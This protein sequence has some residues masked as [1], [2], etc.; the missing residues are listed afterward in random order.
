[1]RP[2]VDETHETDRPAHQLVKVDVTIQRQEPVESR[3]PQPGDALP[4][5]HHQHQQTIE[6]NALTCHRKPI[7]TFKSI[8]P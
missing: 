5:C 8:A 6:M 1:M 2:A 7:V 4:Q 3:R